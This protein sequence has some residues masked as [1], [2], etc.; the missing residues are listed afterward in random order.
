MYKRQVLQPIA[1]P[2]RR[3]LEGNGRHLQFVKA[4]SANIV[5]QVKIVQLFQKGNKDVYK[6]QGKS[7]LLHMLGGLDRPTSG[8]VL[9]DGK[10]LSEFSE[11]CV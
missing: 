8:K 7:T 6:R 2:G 1:C 11:R 3:K 5:V 4:D 9:I 10:E